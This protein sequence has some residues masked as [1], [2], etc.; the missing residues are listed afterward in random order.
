MEDRQS[1][2]FAIQEHLIED[3]FNTRILKM[4]VRYS[5]SA[6]YLIT[7]STQRK[8]LVDVRLRFNSSST[9]KA[10]RPHFVSALELICW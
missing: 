3:F 2:I 6:Y 1:F 4:F 7:I 5:L 9:R 10:S 8:E